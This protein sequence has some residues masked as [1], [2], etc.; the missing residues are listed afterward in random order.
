VHCGLNSKSYLKWSETPGQEAETDK[1]GNE[2]AVQTIGRKRLDVA[3]IA[4]EFY[5][6]L[7]FTI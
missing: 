1:R 7:P 4:C 2:S 3:E 6:H 5:P